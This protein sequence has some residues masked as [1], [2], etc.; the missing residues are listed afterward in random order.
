LSGGRWGKRRFY[1]FADLRI[2][3]AN[4]TQNKI[5]PI[6][7]HPSSWGTQLPIRYKASAH[8][9]YNAHWS[10]PSHSGN[11]STRTV[12]RHVMHLPLC[13]LRLPISVFVLNDVKLVDVSL[14]YSKMTQSRPIFSS[15]ETKTAST[16]PY[17]PSIVKTSSRGW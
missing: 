14:K 13:H 3:Q 12:C 4:Q 5:H 6:P 17:S 15:Y 2:N 8:H 1:G 7:S 9:L 16:S 11:A 10:K